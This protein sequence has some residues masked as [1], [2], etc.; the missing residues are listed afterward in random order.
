MSPE[1][2]AQVE[3]PVGGQAF[4]MLTLSC[5]QSLEPIGKAFFMFIAWKEQFEVDHV[6]PFIYLALSFSSPLES[7]NWSFLNRMLCVC[8]QL[9]NFA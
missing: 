2:T 9:S 6:E 4:K 3:L 5:F 1:N 7:E 8:V